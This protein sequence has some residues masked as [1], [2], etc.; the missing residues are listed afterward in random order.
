M[1]E[2][3]KKEKSSVVGRNLIKAPEELKIEGGK[4][5][6]IYSHFL[7]TQLGFLVGE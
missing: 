7:K 4:K 1:K 6:I 2:R 5:K 3:K